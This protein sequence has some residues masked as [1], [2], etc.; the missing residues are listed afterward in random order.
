[1]FS[2]I[3]QCCR[4]Q[5]CIHDR[6]KQDVRIRMSQKSFFI[7][8]FYAANDEVSAL[9]QTVHIISHSDSH[10]YNLSADVI[11]FQKVPTSLCL[12]RFSNQPVPKPFCPVAA[13]AGCQYR[14]Q[15]TKSLS[16]LSRHSTVHQLLRAVECI[17]GI[18]AV[19]IY[20]FALL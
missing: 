11:L 17:D 12:T 10:T 9:H 16:L 7:R 1:M 5:Q 19:L 8:Y 13:S 18:T 6:M 2:D 15:Y 4:A 20:L 3:S 14:P